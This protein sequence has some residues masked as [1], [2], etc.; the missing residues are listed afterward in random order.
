MAA[1][2][3]HESWGDT[4]AA[5]PEIKQNCCPGTSYRSRRDFTDTWNR[6]GLPDTIK[7]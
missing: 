4:V 1:G 7:R 5:G 6:S 3:E 2:L